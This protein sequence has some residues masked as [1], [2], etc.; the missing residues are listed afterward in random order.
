MVKSE[1]MVMSNKILS[2]GHSMLKLSSATTTTILSKLGGKFGTESNIEN[3]AICI[4]SN[5]DI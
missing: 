4:N 1:T 2:R 3:E 5:S